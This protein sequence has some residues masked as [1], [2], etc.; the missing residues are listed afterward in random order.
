MT[1]RSTITTL[2]FACH[3]CA[4]GGG[5]GSGGSATLANTPPDL[6]GLID[7]SVD[8]NTSLVTTFQATDPDG[9]S[10][11]YSV[12]GED[13]SAF[14]IGAESGEL[15]FRTAPDFENPGDS[16]SDNIYS[17]SVSA[18][19]GRASSTLGVTV[20]VIDV[21]GANMVLIGN[22]FFRPYANSLGELAT[23]AGFGDHSDTGVFAG[24][25]NGIPI[26]LWNDTGERNRQIKEALDEGDVDF[27]GMTGSRITDN[28]N[29]TDGYREW[30]DYALK[31]NPDI[32]IFISVPPIDFPATWEQRAVDAGFTD[33]HSAHAY[34]VNELIN[35]TLIDE[36]RR[37]FPSTTI[38]SIPTGR[39]AKELWRMHMDGLLED[40]IVF[41]GPYEKAL[42][43]DQ[44]GHQG[45]IIV[46]TGTLMWLNGLYQ[47]DL[48]EHEYD[49][50]F[51]TDLHAIAEGIMSEHDPNYSQ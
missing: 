34:F 30:I 44:K 32:A 45:E 40:D 7:Y 14:T 47:V 46:I 20:S 17:I 35:K 26:S 43:T 25:D 8:E 5:G 21:A 12:A 41:S 39:S 51:A 6:S 3:L 16:N 1:I 2:L 23:D 22:S 38:F 50:G 28:P 31:S 9:D 33:V 11:S 19:D 15:V 42:F 10:V 27:F 37:E 13:A 49:T 36:L 29:P 18:S 48:S 4:C 24:G